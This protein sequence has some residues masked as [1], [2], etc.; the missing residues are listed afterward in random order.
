ILSMEA[1]F[2]AFQAA[3]QTKK[4]LLNRLEKAKRNIPTA[5]RLPFGRTHCK[6][7]NTW[8][9][10]TEKQKKIEYAAEMYLKGINTDI[11]TATLDMNW[12]NLLKILK[13]RSGNHWDINFRQ[14]D[15]G[16]NE[17]VPLKIPRLLPEETIQ[18]IH[19][20]TEANKTYTHGKI[21]NT[22]LLSRMIFC[23][24]CG[25]TL[26]GQ[27]NHSNKRYYRHRKRKQDFYPKCVNYIPADDIENAVF[28]HLFKTFG[29]VENIE[30]AITRAIPDPTQLKKLEEQYQLLESKSKKIELGKKRLIIQVKEG[31]LMGE[32]VKNEMQT[33][34]DQQQE[35]N[36]EKETIKSQLE[37]I[38][39]KKR[40][41]KSAQL[42]KRFIQRIYSNPNQLSE[43][44]LEDRKIL[45]QTAFAGKD[46]ENNRLGV[47]LKRY[48]KNGERIIG[49]EINGKLG[50]KESNL[51]MTFDEYISVFGKNY[52]DTYSSDVEIEECKKEFEAIK[53]NISSKRD[54]HHSV[55]FYQ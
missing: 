41:K 32:D 11:I 50:K 38:P 45:F 15:L 27:T 1:V 26:S 5:G 6:E 42:M 33:L 25:S 2:N 44:S 8:G 20:K 35:I 22:Y 47:Y 55:C 46:Q 21:K 7:T 4:S 40:R 49:Y 23:K 34:R 16:I 51:P 28:I 31:N 3:E 19:Q 29:D 30:K 39:S 12:P 53:L 18:A 17:T 37:N 36:L 13:F 54:A 48:N 43:M 52:D 24:H 10:D 9:I 14:D